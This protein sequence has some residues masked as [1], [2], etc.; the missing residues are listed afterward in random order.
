MQLTHFDRWLRQKFVYQTHIRTLREPASIPAGIR[1]MPPPAHSTTHY[2]FLFV[3]T[4]NKAAE[5]LIR[6]LKENGQMFTT[7]IV[8][9]KAWFVPLI[10]PKEKSVTW[11]LFSTVLILIS[12][13]YVMLYLKTLVDDPELR[14]NFLDALQILKR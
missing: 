9:R 12:A 4:S 7:S 10:A 5:T 2:K 13:F 1:A 11:W 6:Q 14:Q 8:D 3:A